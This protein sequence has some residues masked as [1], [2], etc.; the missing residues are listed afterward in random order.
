LVIRTS[1]A[2]ERRRA[3]GASPRTRCARSTAKLDD[4]RSV[5]VEPA[6][7]FYDLELPDGVPP[8]T[9]LTLVAELE[10]GTSYSERV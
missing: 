3:C 1:S 4:G 9:K 7:N 8:W 5:R 6:G 2:A 10:D